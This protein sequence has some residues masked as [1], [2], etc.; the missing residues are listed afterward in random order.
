[1]NRQTKI[2]IKCD[3]IW[4]DHVNSAFVYKEEVV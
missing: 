2:C 4:S 3:H 1:M